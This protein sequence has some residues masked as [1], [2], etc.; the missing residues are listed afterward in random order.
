MEITVRTLASSELS[1]NK[2]AQTVHQRRLRSKERAR[3]R[4][5]TAVEIRAK[6]GL[7]IPTYPCGA[8][9]ITYTCTGK[10]PGDNF[11]RPKDPSNI[12]GEII[13]GPIDA[14]IDLGILP[15]DD[16]KHVKAVTLRLE[17]VKELADEG[18]VI[19]VQPLVKET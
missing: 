1:A 14:L 18:I 5:E 17:R 12:G 19:I 7:D 16:Y 15:D 6:Y 2:H 10:K 9:D 13:K 4:D 11:Y 8:I 3:L